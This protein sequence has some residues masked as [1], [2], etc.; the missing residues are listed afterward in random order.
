MLALSAL[1]AIPLLDRADAMKVAAFAVAFAI[2]I[3]ILRAISGS[4]ESYHPAA[5]M[6]EEPPRTVQPEFDPMG[7][8]I[9]NAPELDPVRLQKFYFVKTDAVPGPADR[10]VFCDELVMQ[11]F[12]PRRDLPWE[13]S[14]VVATPKGLQRELEDKNFA[15]MRLLDAFIFPRY[16][17]QAIRREIFDVVKTEADDGTKDVPDEPQP[18]KQL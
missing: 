2:L 1:I 7:D 5:T 17:L 18:E 10:E 8:D 13:I 14:F 15:S 12:D 11:L 4:G 3:F 6:V 16:D 9:L